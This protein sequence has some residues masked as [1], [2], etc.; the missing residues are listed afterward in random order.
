MQTNKDTYLYLKNGLE[1]AGIEESAA[2]AK[3]IVCHFAGID[4]SV[5]ILNFD[6][7]APRVDCDEIIKLRSSG[8]PLAYIL[9]KKYF[10][11]LP[12]YVDERVL[13]PRYDTEI[14]V[15][16]AINIIKERCF[17][18]VLDMCCGSGCIGISV[19]A[20]TKASVLMADISDGAL[21]VTE[22]NIEELKIKNA[23]VVK[24]DLFANID[25]RYDMI[26]SNPPYVTEE[27]YLTLDV[28]VRDFEPKLALVGAL[29]YYERIA[30]EAK[31]YLE[32]GGYLLFEIGCSQ[33][34][35]V[36]DILDR[37]GYKNISCL[38]DLA[39]R[40]RVIVCTKN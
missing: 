29:E 39:Q 6:N 20:E 13:I 7:T 15:D 8:M 27:E 17:T 3:E 26:V 40:D 32:D 16:A 5:L 38:K 30:S 9:R 33:G 23:A 34:A 14:L 24:S 12:F 36:M 28:G 25:G 2:E 10:F 22:K 19:S 35:D 4:P 37:N 18:R 11:G 1:A 21:K 31:E